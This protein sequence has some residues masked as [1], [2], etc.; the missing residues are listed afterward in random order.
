MRKV[1]GTVLIGLL[2]IVS[3]GIVSAG[4][5]EDAGAAYQ[6]GDY[7]T[8][9]RLFRPLAEQG[10]PDAQFTLGLIYASAQGVVQ[11]FREAEKWFRIAAEQGHAAAQFNLGVMYVAGQVVP[12]NYVLAHVWFNLASAQG[13]QEAATGREIIARLMT[14]AQIAEAWKLARE[15]KPMTQSPR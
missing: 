7:G 12:Q 8:A 10:N 5:Y 4:P 14:P 2:L 9:L 3:G 1:L 11:D 15:W 13:D 6:R